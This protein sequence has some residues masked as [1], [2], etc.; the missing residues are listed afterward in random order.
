VCVCVCVCVCTCVRA[1][2]CDSLRDLAVPIRLPR[3]S[4]ENFPTP[5]NTHVCTAH[6]CA[7]TNILIDMR[8]QTNTQLSYVHMYLRLYSCI[9]HFCVVACERVRARWRVRRHRE[10]DG[11]KPC[12]MFNMDLMLERLDFTLFLVKPDQQKPPLSFQ[13]LYL[14]L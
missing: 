13:F 6:L 12:N 10:T 8:T 14:F 2:Y 5:L 3:Y 1:V 7:Y 4:P 11:E 9:Y